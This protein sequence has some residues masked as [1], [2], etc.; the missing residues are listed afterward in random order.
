M[1][2]CIMS[3]TPVS[4]RVKHGLTNNSDSMQLKVEDLIFGHHIYFKGELKS[5]V[6]TVLD[7]S[8]KSAW[9]SIRVVQWRVG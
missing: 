3:S 2:D 1:R 5:S 8:K 4:H 6:F 9:G 7:G